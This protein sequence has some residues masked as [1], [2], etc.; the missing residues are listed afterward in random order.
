MEIRSLPRFWVIL[1][2]FAAQN[3]DLDIDE[4]VQV[5]QKTNKE[6]V[7]FANIMS[8]IEKRDLM[9]GEYHKYKSYGF[10]S[11]YPCETKSS[12]LSIIESRLYACANARI[13]RIDLTDIDQVYDR[14]I[15]FIGEKG[16]SIA[17]EAIERNILDLYHGENREFIHYFKIYIP[18]EPGRI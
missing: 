5:N 15:N 3:D 7:S 18:I 11:E 10:I 16:Y 8:T 14:L 4:I 9:K 13:L 2:D 17:G 6:W 1:K 12:S